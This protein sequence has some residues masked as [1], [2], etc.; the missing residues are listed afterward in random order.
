[1]AVVTRQVESC[2][3]DAMNLRCLEGAFVVMGTLV[4][5]AE[6]AVLVQRF[7]FFC[8]AFASVFVQ[9]LLSLS[10]RYQSSVIMAAGITILLS[11][12][13]NMSIK[14][15]KIFQHMFVLRRRLL[16]FCLHVSILI[17]RILFDYFYE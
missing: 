2:S 16:E 9:N 5:G 1:M 17:A 8:T 15:L 12:E 6:S 14:C 7:K 11:T 13:R 4:C 3:K 10:S